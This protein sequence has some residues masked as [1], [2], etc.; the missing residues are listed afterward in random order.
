MFAKIFREMKL[1]ELNKL[2]RIKMIIKNFQ[3]IDYYLMSN[4][5]E[6]FQNGYT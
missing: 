4:K 1:N 5:F 6:K 2:N 3:G